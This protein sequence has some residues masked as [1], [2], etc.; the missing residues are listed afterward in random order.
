VP[1]PVLAEEV[2]TACKRARLVLV[3]TRTEA[4][5]RCEFWNELLNA[6]GAERVS[7]DENPSSGE[8]TDNLWSNVEFDPLRQDRF[9][10]SSSAQP[11]H[12]DGSYVPA[13]PSQVIMFC[14]RA[15]PAG[16]ATLF[17]DGV[18]L[19]HVLAEE[20]APLLS[21]LRER[22][23]VFRK[24]GREVTSTV[25]SHDASGP[26]LRWNYYALAADL[27]GTTRQLAEEFQ[28]FLGEITRRSVPRA[29]RLERG[30][31]VLFRDDRL[32]HGRESFLASMPGE[33]CLWK[34]GLRL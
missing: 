21:A 12:T 28:S 25:I 32:L 13:S 3:R 11:L 24:G 16:G 19:E 17:L 2:A 34:G 14:A 10:H 27:D 30:D 8:A 26:L 23:M 6:T 15:A 1:M 9:R 18:E 5:A 4:G 33:R 31:A 7:V 29:V 22:P 20:R